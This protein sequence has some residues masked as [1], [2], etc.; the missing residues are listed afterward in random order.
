MLLRAVVKHLPRVESQMVSLG[1]GCR[2]AT[3]P[4]TSERGAP[5]ED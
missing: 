3:I 2:G 1:Q 5:P 4:G